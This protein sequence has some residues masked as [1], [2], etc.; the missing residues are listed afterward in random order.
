MSSCSLSGVEIC[1]PMVQTSRAGGQHKKN[2]DRRH[3]A[4]KTALSRK[5]SYLESVTTQPEGDREKPAQDTIGLCARCSHV[6][7][8]RSD[9]GSVFYLCQRSFT[10]PSFPKYPRLPVR[11]CGGFQPCDLEISD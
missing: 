9:R 4:A 2:D 1:L 3:C 11:S 7:V 5:C 10:D 8:I 6:K